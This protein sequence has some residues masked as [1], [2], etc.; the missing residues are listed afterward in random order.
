[1][2]AAGLSD[3]PLSIMMQE[4]AVARNISR[5]GGET[6]HTRGHL[7][8]YKLCRL[9]ANCCAAEGTRT[10]KTRVVAGMLVSTYCVR[11]RCTTQAPACSHSI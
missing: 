8:T 9:G 6:A 11:F 3:D 2:A 7:Y 4:R 10:L 1:M 5:H